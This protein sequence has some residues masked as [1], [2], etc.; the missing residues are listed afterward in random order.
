MT[1]ANGIIEFLAVIVEIFL[2]TAELRLPLC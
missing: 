2:L 1:L